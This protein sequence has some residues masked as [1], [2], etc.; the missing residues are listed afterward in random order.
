MNPYPLFI[1]PLFPLSLFLL[2]DEEIYRNLDIIL[3]KYT[4]YRIYNKKA[5]GHEKKKVTKMH[6]HNKNKNNKKLD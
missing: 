6:I 5:K 4:V 3:D 1:F 2:L